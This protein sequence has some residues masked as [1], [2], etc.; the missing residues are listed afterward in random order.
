MTSNPSLVSSASH[1][2]STSKDSSDSFL[3]LALESSLHVIP[4]DLEDADK[5]SQ[6][7][8][9][10]LSDKIDTAFWTRCRKFVVA[11]LR[12]GWFKS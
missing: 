1:P 8:S 5:K 6:G 11:G 9:V 7:L 4:F 10:S 3:A 12:F 2:S